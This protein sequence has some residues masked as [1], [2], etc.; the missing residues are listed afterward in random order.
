MNR[1][2]NGRSSRALLNW[3]LRKKGLPPIYFKLAEKELY[4]EA[5]ESADKQESY[6]KLLRV[7][8]RELFRTIMKNK[9]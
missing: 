9:Q 7:T 1:D 8:I 3:M 2:G 6:S 4:Y 5:L